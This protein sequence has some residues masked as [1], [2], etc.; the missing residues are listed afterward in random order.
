MKSGKIWFNL[1]LI[2]MQN[3]PWVSDVVDTNLT[4]TQKQMLQFEINRSTLFQIYCSID[5]MFALP[6]NIMNN[7]NIMQHIAI[8]VLKYIK[9]CMITNI[10]NLWHCRKWRKKLKEEVCTLRHHGTVF[11]PI[12]EIT[13]YHENITNYWQI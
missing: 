1:K 8:S 3:I 11:S 10:A 9:I 13:F 12:T 6:F 4:Y 7:M 2:L 5:E